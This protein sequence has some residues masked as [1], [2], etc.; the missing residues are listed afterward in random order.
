MKA[1]AGC[2]KKLGNTTAWS[3]H[4]HYGKSDEAL[5]VIQEWIALNLSQQV[6]DDIESRLRDT[7]LLLDEVARRAEDVF[8][9]RA[10]QDFE[11]RYFSE[12]AVRNDQY[13]ERYEMFRNEY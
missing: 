2:S 13:Q 11:S 4:I 7:E 12:S 5:A 8:P 3:D 10:E 1:L 6:I 9:L